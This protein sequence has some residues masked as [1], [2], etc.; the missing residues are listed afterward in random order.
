MTAKGWVYNSRKVGYPVQVICYMFHMEGKV[1]DGG[2]VQV[3]ASVLV[4]V[5]VIVIMC[6]LLHFK[7]GRGRPKSSWP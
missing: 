4:L 6:V 5:A 3:L 1:F 7:A 2:L